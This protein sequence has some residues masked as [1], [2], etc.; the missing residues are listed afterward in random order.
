MSKLSDYL[1]VELHRHLALELDAFYFYWSASTQFKNIY[2][3][4]P[5]F[6]K[7]FQTESDEECGHAQRVIDFLIK[8]GHNV[9]FPPISPLSNMFTEPNVVLS[10]SLIKEHKVLASLEALHN[11]GKKDVDLTGFL[12]EMITEQQSAISELTRKVS[13]VETLISDGQVKHGL[14]LYDQ[15]LKM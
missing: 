5:G 3:S 10:E 12:E 2:T 14:Y 15:K 4:Y 7:Y 1:V 13:E 8:R 11:A 6:S 9:V